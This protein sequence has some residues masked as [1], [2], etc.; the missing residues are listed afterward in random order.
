MNSCSAPCLAVLNWFHQWSTQLL[1]RD[2]AAGLDGGRHGA[3]PLPGVAVALLLFGLMPGTLFVGALLAAL[4]V[5]FGTQII[6]NSS[7]IKE[8][9]ALGFFACSFSLGWF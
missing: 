3:F 8:D 4:L 2:S 7:R 9:T 1:Y 6:S 5:A